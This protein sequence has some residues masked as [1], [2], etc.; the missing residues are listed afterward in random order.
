MKI[1][2]E[3]SADSR[4]T[5]RLAMADK[6]RNVS[7][8]VV[9]GG[10][11]AGL[12]VGFFFLETSALAFIGCMLIGLGFGLGAAALLAKMSRDNSR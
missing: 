11:L 2:D 7:S 6:K 4:P 5:E 9:G 3:R 8:W 1:I 12:G 10:L